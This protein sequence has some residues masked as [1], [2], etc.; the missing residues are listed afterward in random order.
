MTL[1]KASG[2]VRLFI[3]L[4]V[5]DEVRARA[6]EA[7]AREGETVS[8]KWSPVEGLHLTVVFFG[9]LKGELPVLLEAA[10]TVAARHPA[11]SLKIRG[12]G[13]FADRVLW[14]GVEGDVPQLAELAGELHVALN[15]TSDHPVYTPH[16]TLARS[17]AN[18]GDPMLGEVAKRLSRREFGAW[19]ANHL[20]VYETLGGKYRALATI[21]LSLGVSAQK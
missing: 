14:L 16:L 4:D 21:P 15:V 10:K 13:T 7:M 5:S 1:R 17:V 2:P 12:A 19:R 6:G 18:K 9:E 3:A 11:L 20:T 8:A